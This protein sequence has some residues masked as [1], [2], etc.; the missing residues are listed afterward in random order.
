MMF[1]LLV[2]N[3]RPEGIRNNK[4]RSGIPVFYSVL[5]AST[6]SFLLAILAGIK[7]AITVSKILM[8]TSIT[9]PPTGRL[10]IDDTPVKLLIIKLIGI[11]NIIVIPEKFQFQEYFLY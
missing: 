1:I 2:M 4:K 10:A 6:G 5:K 11:F 8:M 7:P 3:I 9:A